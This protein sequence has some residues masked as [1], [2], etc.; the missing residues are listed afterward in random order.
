MAWLYCYAWKVYGTLPPFNSFLLDE[1]AH[2]FDRRVAKKRENLNFLLRNASVGYVGSETSESIHLTEQA[3]YWK[4]CGCI[5]AL[6]RMTLCWPPK[7]GVGGDEVH[8]GLK[9]SPIFET[10]MN[11]CPTEFGDDLDYLVLFF[12]LD[13]TM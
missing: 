2:W 8:L 9:D 5:S 3:E 10:H 7:D 4:L 11:R 1:Y 13:N 12:R 6:A